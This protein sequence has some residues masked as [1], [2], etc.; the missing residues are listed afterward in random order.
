MFEIAFLMATALVCPVTSLPHTYGQVPAGQTDASE[1]Q[2]E[3]TVEQKVDRYLASL[4]EPFNG[5]VL[6]AVG[7]KI[8]INK[9]YGLADRS[10]DIPNTPDTKYEIASVTKHF[11]AVLVLKVVELGLLDLDATIDRY[12]PDYPKEKAGKITIHHL[13]LHQSGIPHHYKGI[14]NYF[15]F[16]DRI[17]HTP[18]EY[19]R[20][21][22][23]ADLA[24]KP[25]EGVTYTSPGYYVL[26]VI[27]EIVSGKSYAE[28]LEEHILV[29]LEMRSTCVDNNLT[30]L[31][32]MAVGYKKGLSGYVS[33]PKEEQS[34]RLAAGDIVST[35]EDL[36]RFQRAVNTEGGGIL[37][38]KS[39]RL[40]LEP[41][42][43]LSDELVASYF[44]ALGNRSWDAGRGGARFFGIG[45]GGS[46]GY[47]SFVRRY[48]EL[49][50]CFVVLSNIQ[51]DRTMTQE[52]FDYLETVLFEE[53]QITTERRTASATPPDDPS[54]VDI[55]PAYLA[56]CEGFY[57][58]RK[59]DAFIGVFRDGDKLF[60][61]RLYDKWGFEDVA[62]DELI[63]IG[64]DMFAVRDE[65]A[66]RYRIAKLS[67]ADRY[68]VTVLENGRI[69]WVARKID[70]VPDVDLVD[71]PGLYYS[72]ELRKTYRFARKE[73]RLTVSDF[74]NRGETTLVPLRAD[75]FGCRHG[76]LVFHRYDDGTIRD[77]HYRSQ[78]VDHVFGS[79]FI[80]K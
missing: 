10:Y 31:K 32:N 18:K 24:H 47:R 49:D 15:G 46:K 58:T 56:A 40:L 21:F 74:L 7:D 13:L 45:M 72:V 78:E 30:V 38:R 50:A 53:M 66:L 54:A 25:G 14:P 6:L 64:E 52:M 65:P 62:R 77:F 79:L 75:L 20:L 43:R 61:Q 3:P 33:A 22:R 60:S 4:P 68:V 73:D 71:Y 29:P 12:L 16:H 51:N 8:L 76:F 55:D 48:I 35:T 36:Y 2:K 26:G 80:R 44:G 59:G 39:M 1:T 57:Q 17:F 69:R 5:T 70:T 63:F 41:Q 23:N 9:G 27:L 42:L 67:A 11:T 19:L 34:N 28:L 37:T